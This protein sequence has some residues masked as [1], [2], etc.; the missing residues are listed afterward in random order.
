MLSLLD[1]FSSSFGPLRLFGYTSSRAVLAALTAFLLMMV[2]MPRL[3]RW[4]KYKKFGEQGAKGDGAIVVDT[5]RQAKAGTP[6]MGGLGLLTC[7]II[8]A[9]LWCDPTVGKTWLLISGMVGYGFLG[10]LDD[11]TKVF[12]GAK[13]MSIR[14]KLALQIALGLG[15]G[16]W[17]WHL[18]GGQVVSAVLTR[19]DEAQ[20][21]LAQE[22]VFGSAVGGRVVI[23]M[24]PLEYS[25]P[26]GLGMVAWAMLMLFAC[27]NAVNFTDGMDGL[28]AGTML[29]AV[30][31]FMVI[32]YVSSHFIAAHYLKIPYVLGNQEVAVFCAALAG[33]CLGF[34]WFNSAPAQ[35]FMGDTG[36]QGLGAGLALVALST[37]QE[38]L[39]LL[40]GFVFFAEALSVALQVASYR[41]R[42]GK[43]IFLCAPIHHHFQYLGWSESKI[44]MRFWLIAALAALI[45]L[46]TLKLR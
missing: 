26:L 14:V 11:R 23:P 42:G 39:I 20:R 15:L 25:L 41:L 30:L 21:I 16:L 3:I 24:L 45:A 38:F 34:L 32:A 8:T 44:V 9:I 13:G 4:L 19:V 17:F 46:S 22:P 5:M 36:S 2:V 28:A 7:V 37:K 12:K 29:I 27:S 33:G 31:A 1:Y 10:Y 6:T 18:D 43:R 35:V 40:V